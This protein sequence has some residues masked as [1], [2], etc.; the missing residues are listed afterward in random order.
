MHIVQ[1][2]VLPKIF[3][4]FSQH[5]LHCLIEPPLDWIS[6]VLLPFLF[7]SLSFSKKIHCCNKISSYLYFCQLQD[8]TFSFFSPLPFLFFSFLFNSPQHFTQFYNHS[9]SIST[10]FSFILMIRKENSK[11]YGVN[12]NIIMGGRSDINIREGIFR[13]KPNF[14]LIKNK[15]KR[16]NSFKKS[17][18]QYAKFKI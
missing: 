9:S 12:I 7:L 5:S 15:G 13:S 3:F 2:S 17:D 1:F 8:I 11:S 14:R 4:F 6:W 18:Y 16:R 10:P